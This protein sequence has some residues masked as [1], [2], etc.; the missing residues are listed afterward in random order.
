MGP[1]I[2]SGFSGGDGESLKV[3]WNVKNQSLLQFL[4][5]KTQPITTYFGEKGVG[6]LQGIQRAQ[7]KFTIKNPKSPET[8]KWRNRSR[9]SSQTAFWETPSVLTGPSTDQTH[10]SSFSAI[11]TP[12]GEASTHFLKLCFHSTSIDS[13]WTSAKEVAKRSLTESVVQVRPFRAKHARFLVT[14]V[15]RE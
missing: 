3:F 7:K 6:N 4:T 10:L 15:E 9:N 12:K 11:I 5:N 14:E 13:G 2:L 8:R 1:E